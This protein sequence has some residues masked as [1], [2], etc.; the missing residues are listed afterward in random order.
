MKLKDLF[1]FIDD[2]NVIRIKD[3]NSSEVMYQG[4]TGLFPLK[5]FDLLDC[6]VREIGTGHEH[7]KDANNQ[8]AW[9]DPVLNIILQ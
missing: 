1:E 6:D 9:G 7:E 2:K 3:D 5:C 8:V 4:E